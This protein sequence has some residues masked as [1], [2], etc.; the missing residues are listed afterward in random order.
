MKVSTVI[1]NSTFWFEIYVIIYAVALALMI[2]YV[3]NNNFDTFPMS[4]KTEVTVRVLGEFLFI[5]FK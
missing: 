2:I 1:R 5:A 4:N 3:N